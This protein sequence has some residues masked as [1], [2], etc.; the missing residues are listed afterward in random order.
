[1]NY[2]VTGL[3]QGTLVAENLDRGLS[4][5]RPQNQFDMNYYVCDLLE[6]VVYF[7]DTGDVNEEDWEQLKKL[8][9]LETIENLAW[10]EEG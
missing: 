5:Y 10:K 8:E 2:K 7:I 9:D 3:R 4:L 6:G 1:M